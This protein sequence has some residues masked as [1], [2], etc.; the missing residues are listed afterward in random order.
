MGGLGILGPHFPAGRVQL[1][2]RRKQ[3]Q[4]HRQRWRFGSVGSV[5]SWEAEIFFL[6]R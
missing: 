3:D 2:L 4:T 6:K 5:E 1:G